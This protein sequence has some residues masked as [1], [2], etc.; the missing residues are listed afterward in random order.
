MI[1]IILP[2]GVLTKGAGSIEGLKEAMKKT[3]Q[4]EE[5]TGESTTSIEESISSNQEQIIEPQNQQAFDTNF[6]QFKELFIVMEMGQSD[7]KKVMNSKPRTPL[8]E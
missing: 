6:G 3:L 4:N 2:E 5:T 7:M 8:D 1:D